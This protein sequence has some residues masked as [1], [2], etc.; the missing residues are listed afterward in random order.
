[1]RSFVSSSQST[2]SQQG[3][4]GLRE[5]RRLGR[6]KKTGEHTGRP[7]GRNSESVLS[8]STLS[9]RGYICRA[10]IM[11]GVDLAEAV[12]E[13]FPATCSYTTQKSEFVWRC[14]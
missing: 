3:R 10:R 13:T 14:H 5:K 6:G 11:I 2:L 1:M 4:R 8:P 12:W 7:G 9:L